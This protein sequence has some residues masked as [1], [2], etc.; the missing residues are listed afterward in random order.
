M[1]RAS[2]GGP[3]LRVIAIFDIEADIA[4]DVVVNRG[5]VRRQRGIEA[6]HRWQI[7]I[8]DID[9]LGGVGR[10]MRRL[11]DDHRH[12]L[13]DEAHAIA[14][15]ERPL[16]RQDLAAA[17]PGER[18]R[19]RYD[20]QA[21]IGNVA[22]DIDGDDARAFLGRALVDTANL[23]MGTIGAAEARIELAGQIPVRTVAAMARYQ[24]LILAP[25]PRFRRHRLT[26]SFEF[27]L[28]I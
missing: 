3:R 26:R 1:R 2:N 16:G 24:P 19:W 14:R 17:P 9:Q 10:L 7:L 13:A 23:G 18:H 21:G 25:T 15:Q 4:R 6:D 5:R 22:A 11:C 27:Y 28:T 12:L 8:I 20:A